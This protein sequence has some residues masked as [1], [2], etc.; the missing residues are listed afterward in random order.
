MMVT[1]RVLEQQQEKTQIPTKG[2]EIVQC[3][4]EACG[5]KCYNANNECSKTP[6]DFTAS[7]I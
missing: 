5:I 3:F 1:K 7:N 4:L 2:L 6:F